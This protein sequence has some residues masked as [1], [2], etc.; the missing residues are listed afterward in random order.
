MNR[1][2]QIDSENGTREGE[3]HLGDY[4]YASPKLDDGIVIRTPN[5]SHE[6]GDTEIFL[7]KQT[8]DNLLK[9]LT[10]RRQ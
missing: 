10:S 1:I 5:P 7:D 3:T 4:T 9:Y 2:F 6:G 8:A